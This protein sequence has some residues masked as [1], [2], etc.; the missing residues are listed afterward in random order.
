MSISIL[1]TIAVIGI[2]LLLVLIIKFKVQPFIALL[3]V[4]LFVALA[5]GIPA[6]KIWSIITS[7]MGGLLGHVALIIGLGAMLGKLI[8]HSG[9]T[10]SLAQYFTNKLGKKRTIAALTIAA[11]ILGIPV[12]FEVGFIVVI[13]IIYGFA[14]INNLSPVKFGLPVSGA[15]LTVHVVLSPHPG[16]VAAISNL[17]ADMGLQ[18]MIAL[19]IAITVAVVGVYYAKF[20]NRKDYKIDEEILNEMS[21]TKHA[22]NLKSA[23][24]A[25]TIVA[26]IVAPILLI[27]MG[28]VSNYLMGDTELSRYLGLIG[29]PGIALLIAIFLA[30]YFIGRQQKWSIKKCSEIMDHSLPG[31]ATIIFVIGGGGIFGKVLIESGIGKSLADAL[32][33]INLP[34]IP[35]AFLMS[36][37]LRASQG[38]ATVAIIT[39]SSLLAESTAELSQVKIALITISTCFGGLGLSHVNDAGFWVVTKYLGLSVSDGLKTWTVLT[40]VLGLT[41]F[42]LTWLVWYFV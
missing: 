23:P 2:L 14:K 20:L 42:L 35:A 39:T 5:T 28:T 9:G 10:Y 3:L 26:L 17:K 36:L 15:M 41:G 30:C 37:A 34:L 19:T 40:T 24:H 13:P 16:P 11:F 6:N 12:F 4:S 25:Y 21:N 29:A 8:E 7:G 1:L 33:I 38:S 32:Y 31:I 27:M 18:T 22:D